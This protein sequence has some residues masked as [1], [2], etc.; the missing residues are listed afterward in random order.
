MMGNKIAVIFQYN[1]DCNDFPV[2][3]KLKCFLLTNFDFEYEYYNVWIVLVTTSTYYCTN[4]DSSQNMILGKTLGIGHKK[5]TKEDE[6][7]P[8]VHQEAEMGNKT[9]HSLPHVLPEFLYFQK[10]KP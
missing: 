9:I 3:R 8:T 1:E 10:L 2:Q 7:D 5:P 6:L 4:D